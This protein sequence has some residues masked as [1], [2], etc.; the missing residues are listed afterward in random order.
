MPGAISSTEIKQV[1]SHEVMN[2]PIVNFPYTGR[3]LSDHLDPLCWDDKAGT[4]DKKKSRKHQR[5]M[6]RRALEQNGHLAA[7]ER[8]LVRTTDVSEVDGM[9]DS[10]SWESGS[11]QVLKKDVRTAQEASSSFGE[12]VSISSE[13]LASQPSSSQG[14]QNLLASPSISGKRTSPFL[15][16]KSV[17]RVAID[18]EMV[19]TGPS[20][21]TSELARC[22]VVSYNGDVIYDKYI[23]PERPIVDYRTRWSGITWKHM[24]KAISFR[25]AQGEVSIRD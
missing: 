14:L 21:K 5:Y 7:K 19:G 18:C 20:G 3:D 13:E 15:P 2:V 9:Q 22:T 1:G 12:A 4:Q 8:N 17:K 6:M 24:R 16:Q 11:H 25:I 10:S 23:L